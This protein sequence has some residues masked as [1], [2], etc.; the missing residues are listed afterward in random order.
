MKNLLVY[1]CEEYCVYNNVSTGLSTSN[2]DSNKNKTNKP[3]MNYHNH[4]HTLPKY[5]IEYTNYY[6]YK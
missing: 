1:L 3:C 4:N 2:N 6:K 5:K